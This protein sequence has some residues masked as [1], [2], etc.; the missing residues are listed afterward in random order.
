ML[1]AL[2]EA[3]SIILTGEPLLWLTVGILIG[4]FVG[5]LPGIGASLGMALILP[6]TLPLDGVNAII[7]L[8]S[9][10]S[11]GMYGGSIAAILLNAPGTSAAAATTLDGY[12]LSRQG[13]AITAL[14]MSAVASTLGGFITIVLLILISPFLVRMVLLFGSPQYFLIALLGIA[15]I[16]I[17]ARGSLIR[18]VVSGMFGLLIATIG[19][20]PMVPQQRFTFGDPALFDGI[21]FVAA[22]IGLF[23]IAEMI[24]LAGEEGGVAQTDMEITGS[25]RSGI[26][27]VLTKPYLI[28]KSSLIGMGIGSVPG[29]GSTV[30]TFVSYAEALRSSDDPDSFGAGNHEGLIAAESAN[31]A[32]IPG[33]LIPTFSFGIPGSGS[34]A[35][36]LGGLIMHGLQPGPNLFSSD[37]Q[38]TYA[39][40][41]ALFLGNFVILFVGLTFISRMGVLTKIDTDIIIPMI[42]VLAVVGGFLLRINWIDVL[43]VFGLGIIGYYMKRYNYS[44]IAF[45][46]GIVLGPIAE[47]NF[48]RSLTLSDG[49]L[50]IFVND[51]LSLIIVIAIVAL[52]I[53]P[54]IRGVFKKQLG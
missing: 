8:V 26:S 46:L 42:V 4:I 30:S 23:A 20:A 31:N 49:S 21:S 32:T 6:L 47:E 35:V 36:L 53:G 50:M 34:T 33:S 39:V 10:Y 16:A 52:T 22:L 37:L 45:V 19:M 41:I 29:A 14:A 11:G 43:T 17:V 18:G 3:I 24:N 9:I 13:Q 7:L 15:M 12:P 25:I 2:S 40:F 48:A 28:A 1:D 51:P 54:A 44:V 27:S 5:S 38:I